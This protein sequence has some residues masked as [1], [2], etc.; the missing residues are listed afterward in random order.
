ME[1]LFRP[2]PTRLSC[3]KP[4]P[5]QL[6][7][8]QPNETSRFLSACCFSPMFTKSLC[9]WHLAS[10]PEYSADSPSS[11]DSVRI[12]M[13]LRT[14]ICKVPAGGT[15]HLTARLRKFLR[16][17]TCGLASCEL[18]SA[19]F[20]FCHTVLPIILRAW[21]RPIFDGFITIPSRRAI[22]SRLR[23]NFPAV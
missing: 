21:K 5:S 9:L 10:F 18:I 20:L 7:K 15:L 6:Q 2:A 16:L 12:P 11:V 1:L 23:Y 8:V 19:S 17:V 4:R 13:G 3:Q 14:P 22:T